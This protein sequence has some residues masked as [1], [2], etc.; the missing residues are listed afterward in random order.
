MGRKLF[1]RSGAQNTA[2]W[3]SFYCFLFLVFLFID[4]WTK[5]YVL[6]HYETLKYIGYRFHLYLHLNSSGTLSHFRGSGKNLILVALA[7]FSFFIVVVPLALSPF[8]RRCHP[9]LLGITLAMAGAAGNI[10]DHIRLG[11]VVDFLGYTVS[12][13]HIRFRDFLLPVHSMI[14]NIAD[15]QILVGLALILLGAIRLYQD[16]QKRKIIIGHAFKEGK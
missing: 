12:K 15:V 3:L 9:Y 2:K 14:F 6:V 5:D 4:Q 11:Y 16:E 8:L 1:F 13:P 7:F 10:I